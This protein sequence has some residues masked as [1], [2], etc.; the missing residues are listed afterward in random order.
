L[1]GGCVGI[2]D[3]DVKDCCCALLPETV[4]SNVATG[5]WEDGCACGAR[6]CA[7]L[8]G[9][10]E[11]FV[12]DS[13]GLERLG[14]EVVPFHRHIIVAEEHQTS[15]LAGQGMTYRKLLITSV[16]A[17]REVEWHEPETQPHTVSELLAGELGAIEAIGHGGEPRP[18]LL[19]PE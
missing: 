5:F 6:T 7:A 2:H 3:T 16:T 9:V 11:G 17:I 19:G 4:D 15:F 8:T 10:N 18:G 13:S 1:V 14:A 12:R